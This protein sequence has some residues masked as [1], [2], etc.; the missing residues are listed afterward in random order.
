MS[1]A[2][3]AHLSHVSR[4]RLLPVKSHFPASG[5]YAGR[6]LEFPGERIVDA[7][8][9]SELPSEGV[10]LACL[11]G[12][13][14]NIAKTRQ[15]YHHHCGLLQVHHVLGLVRQASRGTMAGFSSYPKHGKEHSL[16]IRNA[17]PAK[18]YPGQGLFEGHPVIRQFAGRSLFGHTRSALLAMLYG[19][20]D[21]SFYLRQLVVVRC[22]H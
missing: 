7:G 6:Q 13:L 21:Q 17:H 8:Q 18:C 15:G 9:A 3:K 16:S 19:H 10:R 4:Y 22:S 14:R 2:R 5:A 11:D 1:F 20:A 12:I